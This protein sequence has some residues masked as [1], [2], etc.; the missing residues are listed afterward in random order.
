MVDEIREQMHYQQLPVRFGSAV[1]THVVAA[2]LR[3][4]SFQRIVEELLRIDAAWLQ[5][6]VVLQA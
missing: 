6:Q 2:R 5:M 3:L 1:A 4:R